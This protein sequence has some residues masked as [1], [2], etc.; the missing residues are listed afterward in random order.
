MNVKGSK[1]TGRFVFSLGSLA[2]L[3]II[4]FGIMVFILINA[5]EL[6]PF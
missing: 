5:K 4:F 1:L 3:E 2:M 6:K